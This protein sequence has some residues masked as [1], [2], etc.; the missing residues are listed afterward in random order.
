MT[1]FDH[2][3]RAASVLMVVLCLLVVPAVA[4]A[5]FSATRA[6]GLS[7]GTDSMETPSGITGAYQCTKSGSTE[8]FSVTIGGFTDNGPA[9]PTYTYTLAIGS[10]IKDTDSST[11]KTRTLSSSRSNDGVSTT[12]RV[13]IQPFL[14]NWS[15]GTGTK[16]IVCPS[17][18]NQSGTF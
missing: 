9:G 11:G 5:T 16:D 14:H 10:T 18:A 12:W 17:S 15:G 1:V 2:S 13:G 6:Q 3:R 4:S 7:V 8:Y